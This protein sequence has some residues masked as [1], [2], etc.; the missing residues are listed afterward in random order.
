MNIKLLATSA[1]V[2]T[3][4]LGV[5]ALAVGTRRFVLNTFESFQGGDA[6]GVAIGSDGSVRAGLTIAKSP[7][8]DAQSV[9]D[10]VVA[11]D[12]SVLLG[13]GTGGR[14]LR[15]RGGQTS[16]V[17]NTGT[18]AASALANGFDGML[19][20]GTFPNGAVYKI[21]PRG[22][23][24]KDAAPQP[25]W[26]TL[27][28]TENVWDLA[29]DPGAKVLYAA[30]GP[31][32]KLFR[33]DASGK[34]EVY[35]DSDEPHLVS[36]ALASDGTVYTGSS[37]KALLYRLTAP[38]RASVVH[39]FEGDDVRSIV[40][41]PQGMPH[42]GELY[43]TA[44]DYRGSVKSLRPLKRAKLQGSSDDHPDVK[45]G[46]GRLFRVARSG[47]VEPLLDDNETHFVAL[48]LDDAG[49]PYVGTGVDGKVIAVDDQRVVRV[50]ADTEERQAAA[51][52]L[53]G[54]A[55]FVVSSD[56]VVF[57]EVTGIGGATATWTSKVLDAGGR[58]TFGRL[59]WTA[60]G[61][62]EFQTRSGNTDKPDTTWS[63]W[64]AAL[65]TAGRVISPPGRFVQARARWSKDPMAVLDEVKLAFVNDNARPVLTSIDA[66]ESK[67]DTGG[68]SIPQSGG[69]PEDASPKL[70]LRWKLEN[71]DND[72]L[73][74][75]LFFQPV[76]AK[77][78]TSLL[79]S[80]DV[81]TKREYSW[82]TSGLPEG[83]YRVRVDVSDELA[84]PPGAALQ[85]SLESAV[86]AIDNTAP[87]LSKLTLKGGRLSG[88]A[89]DGIGPIARIEVAA[90]GDRPF[91]PL[92]PTDGVFDE[93]T[94]SFDVDISSVLTE[95]AQHLVVRVFDVS[96]NRT[97]ATVSR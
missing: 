41:A 45:S 65:P 36:V 14:I 11:S 12:G 42:A 53:S 7:V 76:G 58:A 43:V 82:D 39:D 20:A 59:D 84:N 30:T 61:A 5:D 3:G 79:D 67:S 81:L 24:S 18:M 8:A 80:S 33:I 47:S 16:V 22:E 40:I 89:S 91:F 75:R 77:R 51:V 1:L 70:K 62:L 23:V 96:G 4:L 26:L 72:E 60:S 64:S 21:D 50:V 85:H 48:A 49:L 68:T 55:R 69:A 56:P 63:D 34:A 6:T 74:F 10:A 94:E 86:F 73:R 35:F 52:V 92:A 93:A 87:V 54:G 27:P 83:R 88:T 44:N 28:D 31:E 19:F 13:T 90:V 66:G 29:Y 97:T 37:G 32:G 9:W 15:V 57:H 38:G 78:W 25:P 2:I 46:R 95:G 71:P 17:A